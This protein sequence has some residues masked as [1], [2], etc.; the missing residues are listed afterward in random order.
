MVE[1]GLAGCGVSIQA[2][3]SHVPTIALVEAHQ[4]AVWVADISV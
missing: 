1:E 4:D 2:A 3:S